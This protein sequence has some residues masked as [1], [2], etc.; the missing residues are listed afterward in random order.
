MLV[1][2]VNDSRPGGLADHLAELGVDALFTDDPVPIVAR[3]KEVGR[4][5]LA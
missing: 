5:P 3:M 1:Y 4:S 2:T